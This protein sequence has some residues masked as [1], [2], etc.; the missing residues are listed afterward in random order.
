MLAI[1]RDAV[2]APRIARTA[3]A[4][5]APLWRHPTPSH[6]CRRMP[7]Y[8]SLQ[9]H[10]FFA[11]AAALLRGAQP[12]VARKTDQEHLW[13]ELKELHARWARTQWLQAQPC[14]MTSIADPPLSA[15]NIITIAAQLCCRHERGSAKPLGLA[16]YC[17]PATRPR[18]Q[19]DV[20]PRSNASE[21][22]PYMRMLCSSCLVLTSQELA[23]AAPRTR[24]QSLPTATP[25]TQ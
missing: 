10:I 22:A 3:S 5:P 14:A 4:R 18:N 2:R 7:P 17:P 23:A 25:S 13:F 11:A 21:R 20:L 1:V 16:F 15:A 9:A 6:R 19:C 12:R 8:H 24:L